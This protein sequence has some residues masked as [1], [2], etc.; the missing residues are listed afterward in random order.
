MKKWALVLLPTLAIVQVDQ[1]FGRA[2]IEYDLKTARGCKIR[3][4]RD[5]QKPEEKI[6]KAEW[7]GTCK[8]GF[9]EGD[10][11]AR[12][13]RSDGTTIETPVATQIPPVMATS[14]S[15]SRG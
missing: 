7:T 9:A 4:S 13:R 5:P 10:G 12:L 15:P 8:S 14:K 11:I 1:A 3:M 2:L 6:E